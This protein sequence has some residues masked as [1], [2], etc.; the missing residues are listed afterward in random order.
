MDWILYSIIH[1]G[2][3]LVMS[4]Q[5]VYCVYKIYNYKLCL[6]FK[7][8]YMRT[9]ATDVP[10]AWCVLRAC[11]SLK[12]AERLEVLFG[13]KTP[14]VQSTLCWIRGSDP[15]IRREWENFV[16]CSVIGER[17]RYGHL[18]I[19]LATCLMLS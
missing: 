13:V 6:Y 1:Y 14:G 19:T 5:C 3:Q 7:P 8:R 18:Q 12:T 11:A 2:F 17:I 4:M 9:V 16:R 10:V 15:P